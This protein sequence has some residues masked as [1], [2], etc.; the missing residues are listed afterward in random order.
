MELAS[1]RR[2][3]FREGFW[4]D[5]VSIIPIT[6]LASAFI[7]PPSSNPQAWIYVSLVADCIRLTRAGRLYQLYWGMKLGK[8]KSVYN[9]LVN[10]FFHPIFFPFVVLA[11]LVGGIFW[12]IEIQVSLCLI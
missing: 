10:K 3:Y 8:G 7:G 12:Y 2:R 5:F 11:S 6:E 1:I 9:I 4:K